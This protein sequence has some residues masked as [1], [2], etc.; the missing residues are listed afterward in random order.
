VPP[1]RRV[2][3]VRL[4]GSLSETVSV[5]GPLVPTTEPCDVIH[6]DWDRG[7]DDFD[8]IVRLDGIEGLVLS[9]IHD[10]WP[11][12]GCIWM[13]RSEILTIDSLDC[14]GPE[15][16]VLDRLGV[17][18]LAVDPELESLHAVVQHAAQTPAPVA[19]YSRA[20]GSGEVQVGLMLSS[21]DG[22]CTMAEVDPTGVQTGDE[23]RLE[24]VEIIALEW[25][26]DY[27]AALG[28]L[29]EDGPLHD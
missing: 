18:L 26:T 9:R 22:T 27:L 23:M 1:Q 19:V 28:I 17:R 21:D 15:V 5:L 2:G 4:W 25:S 24:L 14:D 10:Y 3:V 13:R 29:L 20:T 11:Q 7:H 16:R 8:A 6:I 12:A